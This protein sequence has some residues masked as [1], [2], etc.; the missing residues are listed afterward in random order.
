MRTDEELII[1]FQQ[2]SRE[3]FDELFERYRQRVYAFFRRRGCDTGRSEE[4]AQETFL[5]IVRGVDRYEP[6]ATFRRYLFGIAFR[7]LF[8]ER[9]RNKAEGTAGLE[10]EPAVSPPNNADALWV[11]RAVAQLDSDHREVLLLREFE[12]L[13]YDEIAELVQVPL[14]TVRSRLFRARVELRAFLESE[15]TV[16]RDQKG[17][18]RCSQPMQ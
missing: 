2:G 14:N 16:G 3:S 11:R 17:A 9:R 4:L 13:R 1:L 15:A 18:S 12:G 5:A 7:Q 6:R 10:F 8:A